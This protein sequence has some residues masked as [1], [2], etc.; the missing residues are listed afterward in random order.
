MVDK[1]VM[2]SKKL[3]LSL[4]DKKVVSERIFYP[5]WTTKP[6]VLIWPQKF[7]CLSALITADGR[8][9]TEIKNIIG[10]AKIALY[11]MRIILFNKS[12]S[13]EVRK[14]IIVCYVEHILTYCCD[15]WTI[16][17][18]AKFYLFKKN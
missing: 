17:K 13:F 12:L 2:V 6:M 18:E 7:K 15:P 14:I 3:H 16:S 4:N 9:I 5:K 1:M 11:R 10:Q 8:S